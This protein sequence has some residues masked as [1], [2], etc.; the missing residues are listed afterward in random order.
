[1]I[2]TPAKFDEA[3]ESVEDM[4]DSLS[5]ADNYVAYIDDLCQA[6]FSGRILEVGTGNGDLT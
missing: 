3:D 4:L 1:M 2:R 5:G 6:H